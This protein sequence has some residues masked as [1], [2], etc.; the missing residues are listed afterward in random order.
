M[1]Y[2]EDYGPIT[3]RPMMGTRYIPDTVQLTPEQLQQVKE[4]EQQ[5]LEYG[6]QH[7]QRRK[8]ERVQVLLDA[9]DIA[10]QH[11]FFQQLVKMKGTQDPVEKFAAIVL[12]AVIGRFANLDDPIIIATK[13]L[14]IAE[15]MV[16]AMRPK[17]NNAD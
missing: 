6:K 11:P 14:A 10:Q 4:Y 15:A 1:E 5:Q 2:E 17:V 12:P 8:Q 13:T 7:E 3:G 16:N 9:M